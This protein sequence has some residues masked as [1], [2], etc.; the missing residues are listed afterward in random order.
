MGVKRPEMGS[1][2][3]FLGESA[4]LVITAQLLF[5]DTVRSKVAS[6]ES[7]ERNSRNSI[8]YSNLRQNRS[9]PNFCR[10]RKTFMDW[11]PRSRTSNPRSRSPAVIPQPVDYG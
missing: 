7:Q 3:R 8:H 5:Q 9:S 11:S 10:K 2:W 4:T 6:N 1:K